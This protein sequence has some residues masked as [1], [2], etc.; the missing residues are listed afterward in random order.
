MLRKTKIVKFLLEVFNILYHFLNSLIMPEVINKTYS[1]R[2]DLAKLFFLFLFFGKVSSKMKYNIKKFELYKHH[3]VSIIIISICF[4]IL[5]ICYLIISIQ[6]K[7]SNES[8]I[9]P[10]PINLIFIFSIQVMFVVFYVFLNERRFYYYFHNPFLFMFLLG[11]IGF[12]FL[13]PIEIIYFFC[14][15]DDSKKFRKGNN[16]SDYIKFKRFKKYPIFYSIIYY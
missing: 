14:F 10:F 3:T 5:F 9:L 4:L 11:L 2:I 13:I 6:N 7:I 1:T 8:N 15:G 16:F 12:L